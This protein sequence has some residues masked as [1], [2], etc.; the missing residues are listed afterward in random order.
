MQGCTVRH[1]FTQKDLPV[2]LLEYG[3]RKN[4]TGVFA[5]LPAHNY[6]DFKLSSD[7]KLEIPALIN[8]AGDFTTEAG[9]DLAGQNLL[10][11][12]KLIRRWMRYLETLAYNLS[13]ERKEP[14][15]ARCGHR[16]IFRATQQWFV[17]L[18]HK[19]TGS[20]K[21]LRERAQ[22]E[23]DNLIR[24]VPEESN[25]TTKRESYATRPLGPPEDFKTHTLNKTRLLKMIKTRH[26]WCISRQ[27]DW[28]IP[29]P[30]ITC[31][32][33]GEAILDYRVIQKARDLIASEG[34]NA[35]YTKDVTEVVPEGLQCPTCGHADFDKNQDR[36]VLDMW[37]E[38]GTSWYSTLIADH[39]LRFPANLCIEGKDQ[40]RGW[41][42]LSLLTS[43]M[44]RGRSPFTTL[45]THGFILDEKK[46]K[47]SKRLNTLVTLKSA[48]DGEG[49]APADLI[50]LYFVWN[51]NIT[52]D[53]PLSIREILELRPV[54][55]TFRNSFRYLL[56]NLN[57]YYPSEDSVP[58]TELCQVD[59]WILSKLYR[60]IEEVT[61]AFERYDFP[62]AVEKIHSFCNDDLSK[63]Y[64][65][66][67]KDRLYS[68]AL[69][70][71]QR[72]S[73]QTAMHSILIAMVKMLAP[74]LVYTCEEVWGFCPGISD[75]GSVHLSMWPDKRGVLPNWD[76]HLE[77]KYE[78][79]CE[80]RKALQPKFQKTPYES[81][82]ASL[83]LAAGSSSEFSEDFIKN[84]SEELREFLIVSE[85]KVADSIYGLEEVP[86]LDG[87]HFAISPSP[88]PK[89]YR[90]RQYDATV[91]NNTNYPTFCA[92]CADVMKQAETSKISMP[93]TVITQ[94]TRP[95]ELAFYLKKRGIRK[96]AILNE[97]D[98][99]RAYY[100]HLPSQSVKFHEGLQSL[101]DY[102]YD[103]PDFKNHAAILLGLGEHTDVL[104]GIG[105]HQLDRG[106][107]LGGTREFTYS[108]I[109]DFIENL[110]RLSYG[111]SIKNSIGDLPHGGGKSIIDTCELDLKVH[112][113][114]RKRI[115]RD[116]GQFTATLFGRYICAEDIGNTTKDTREM[117]S[118]CRH[119]MCLP[120]SVGGSGNP[121]RF[122]ALVGWLA[123]RAGWKHLTG[124]DSLDGL[125]I[126][127]QGAGQVGQH[128]IDILTEGNPGKILI[129][130][131]EQGQ[132]ENV[133]KML[134]RKGKFGLLNQKGWK[135]PLDSW[136][137]KL[138]VDR[139]T[140]NTISLEE[141]NDYILYSDCDILVPVAVG[142][143]IYPA[144]VSFLR[145]KL[146]VPIANNAYSDNDVV[147]R[148][149]WERKIVDV[150]ENNVNW[151]GATVAASELY[152]Y[153]E[154]HVIRWCLEKAYKETESLLN[155]AKNQGI[156]PWEILKQ[157]AERQMKQPHPIVEAARSYYFIG[158][159]NENFSEWIKSKWLPSISG[160][161]GNKY[162]EYVVEWAN[163]ELGK[164]EQ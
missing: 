144:N 119:V 110:L 16:V 80:L 98:R 83:T 58:L 68:E 109:G 34:S 38:S 81:A 74:V 114:L 84:S 20:E 95:A 107:P 47:M 77:R 45:L 31:K 161:D 121:S 62:D 9:E 123:A 87:L 118:F 89:C 26:D 27:R 113:E 43:I 12:E 147:A 55:L 101:A 71:Q 137:D 70:S 122:T 92:R 60:L 149:V 79:M 108:S 39:R 41:F 142:K 93:E 163:N 8:E 69:K 111:M 134:Y 67:I 35:W 124:N 164:S 46:R 138:Q 160:I 29:I 102:V 130:D 3:E 32:N 50:R 53:L 133:K 129:A 22:D 19:E 100:F 158:K 97:G 140:R 14:H 65:E 13:D 112:R 146:I 18:D 120:E 154:D 152:G 49:G 126:A 44:A 94:D 51:K 153:D 73:A 37:F 125:T 11:A 17:S 82:G 24:W 150:V 135:D 162:A 85:V 56:G 28:G 2:I 139:Q 54:Y 76:R 52:Q 96:L 155:D 48:L 4:E 159:I 151:G 91:G 127:I 1:P 25:Q 21:T 115:Y 141:T 128:F 132:I 15:G 75:C 64:F 106:S 116:F 90:C 105:I 143:V 10:E 59:Q 103:H 99:C 117:L 6:N 61:E 63:I 5:V 157:R 30:V 66:V 72:R 145:C 42:Q 57:N 78:W 131:K 156:P 7:Y 40:H 148:K 36:S 88:Y 136:K 23:I 104:F 33:C 86:E